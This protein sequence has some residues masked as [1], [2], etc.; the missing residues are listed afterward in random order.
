[1]ASSAPTETSG[2]ASSVATTAPASQPEPAIPAFPGAEGF[3]IYAKGGRGGRVYLVTALE[4][5]DKLKEDAPIPGSLR[6]AVEALGPRIIIFRVGGTIELKGP[7]RVE[8]SWI[9]IAGQ[10]APG[11]GICLKG[12]NLSVGKREDVIVRYLRVRPGDLSE[13]EI[14]GVFVPWGNN[15][16]IDHCSACWSTDEVPGM[17]GAKNTSVQWTI[18]AMTLNRSYHR[19]GPHGLGSIIAGTGWASFH[20]NIYAYCAD[21]SPRVADDILLDFRNNVIYDWGSRAGYNAGDRIRMNH[22]G[23]YLK[24][25]PATDPQ[26]GQSAFHFSGPAK[27]YVAGNLMEG[28]P[29]ATADNWLM[30]RYPW[31]RAEDAQ[32]EDLGLHQPFPCFPVTTTSAELAYKQVLEGCGA[33]LPQ[34]DSLDAMLVEQIRMGTGTI[35]DSQD[36][37]G[38]WPELAGGEAPPDADEDGMPDQWEKTHGLDPNDAGDAS[39]LCA[40]DSGYTNIEDY[41]NSLVP[42]PPEGWPA[43]PSADAGAILAQVQQVLADV[44]HIPEQ[45]A[46]RFLSRT[47]ELAALLKPN[48]DPMDSD[49]ASKLPKNLQVDAGNGIKMGFVLIPAGKFLMGSPEDEPGREA[50]EVQHPV[51]ISRPFYLAPTETTWGQYSAVAGTEIGPGLNAQCPAIV[52]WNEAGEFRLAISKKSGYRVRLPTEAGWEYACRAGTTTA[53]SNGNTISAGQAAFDSKSRYDIGS[54]GQSPDSLLPVRSFP[55]NAW[56]LYDMHGNAWEWVLEDGTRGTLQ[57]LLLTL[58]VHRRWMLP[59]TW[60]TASTRRFSVVGPGVRSLS[61]YG[62]PAGSA[63]CPKTLMVSV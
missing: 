59:Y 18:I 35:I 50:G 63:T 9:T 42:A 8:H 62:R 15:I 6:A 19:K 21:R 1:M 17:V 54:S 60:T 46:P 48:H 5:Y 58:Q 57:N 22:G 45:R 4:D 16:I 31:R 40:S 11:G 20:H 43:P 44:H 38:G 26:V 13:A 56:G 7:L 32:G 53:F 61:F 39:V 10:T 37:V 27:A 23:N 36:Q 55:P 51:T 12:Y 24:A 29:E 33:V 3:G 41:I 30:M 52:N 25:G 49:T 14:D 34:R 2:G 47:V 28:L